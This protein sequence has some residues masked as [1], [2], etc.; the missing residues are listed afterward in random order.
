MFF[1][2]RLSIKG[3]FERNDDYQKWS[4]IERDIIEEYSLTVSKDIN[5]L[6]LEEDGQKYEGE[7]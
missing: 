2:W 4:L 5:I 1:F 6:G 7:I 3:F